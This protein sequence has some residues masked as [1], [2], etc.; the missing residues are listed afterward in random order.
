MKRRTFTK[1][2]IAFLILSNGVFIFL[3]L[4][5]PH[6]PNHG[7][8]RE[9]IISRLQFTDLQIQKFEVLIKEHR[10]EISINEKQIR[11]AKN[12]Y[13]S[14][15]KN[16]EKEIDSVS[17]TTIL[18]SQEKIERAHFTHFKKVRKLCSKEQLSAFK[19]LMNDIARIFSP[20]RPPH[21]PRS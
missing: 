4:G 13:F 12:N 16:D 19:K 1:I 17:L 9:E 14:G 21:P 11:K 15:L 6:H 20:Q 3:L 8:S 10:S 7:R 5:R 18:A 2:S